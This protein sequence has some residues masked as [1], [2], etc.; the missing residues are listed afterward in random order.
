M[1]NNCHDVRSGVPAHT[2]KEDKLG[3]LIIPRQNI[4]T[5]ALTL[6]CRLSIKLNRTVM[7]IL[8]KLEIRK[9]KIKKD[10]NELNYIHSNI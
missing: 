2:D 10:I 5:V 4:N 1:S 6:F 9:E 3:E 8:T 7:K